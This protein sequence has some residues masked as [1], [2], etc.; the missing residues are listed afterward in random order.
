MYLYLE[1]KAHLSN[2]LDV[3]M[4]AELKEGEASFLRAQE[5]LS[6][7]HQSIMVMEKHVCPKR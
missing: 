3:A 7:T 1:S 6:I 4:L 5:L 2:K